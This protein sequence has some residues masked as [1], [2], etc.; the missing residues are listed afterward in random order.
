MKTDFLKEMTMKRFG[1][2][3]R[4]ITIT[5][6][7]G[8]LCLAGGC[9]AASVP[10]GEW[11]EGTLTQSDDYGY[12]SNLNLFY[13]DTYQ[14]PVKVAFDYYLEFYADTDAVI[15]EGDEEEDILNASPSGAST[16]FM[17][18]SESGEYYVY[19]NDADLYA[20]GEIDYRF[21]ITEQ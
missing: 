11:V 13:W 17:A 1:R 2:V 16:T 4:F 10:L 5:L 8:A 6:T 18:L 3:S 21:R 12:D 19:V 7:I 14:L 9:S 20:Y 15:F